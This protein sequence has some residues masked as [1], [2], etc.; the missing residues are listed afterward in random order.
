MFQ[1][2][3]KILSAVTSS[4]CDWYC[5]LLQLFHTVLKVCLLGSYGKVT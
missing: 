5:D 3:L 1:E 2:S 4:V